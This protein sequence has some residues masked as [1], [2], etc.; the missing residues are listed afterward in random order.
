MSITDVNHITDP[1]GA[2]PLLMCDIKISLLH[3]CY[4]G[5]K[6]S[7]ILGFRV[8]DSNFLQL[9]KPWKESGLV[10]H[11]SQNQN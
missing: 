10:F 3:Q 2:N 11:E 6:V 9:P 4:M 5:H 1:R 8:K 7:S